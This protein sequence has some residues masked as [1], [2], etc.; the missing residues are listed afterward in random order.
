[1]FIACDESG[2]EGEK[3]IGGVT[4]VFA[5]ASVHLGIDTAQDCIRELRDRIRSPATEY[6]ANHVLRAKHRPVLIWLLG[7]LGPLYGNARVFLLDKAQFVVRRLLDALAE[8]ADAESFYREGRTA[9][10][11]DEWQGFLR[12][13]NDLMRTKDNEAAVDCFLDAAATLLDTPSAVGDILKGFDRERAEAF[14]K[15]LLTDPAMVPPMDA[16]VPA[17]VHAV[18]RWGGGEPV[19]VLHDRQTTLSAGRVKQIRAM[20]RLDSLELVVAHTDSRIQMAD[21]VA[22]VARKIVSDRLNGRGDEELMALVEPYAD[23]S[24]PGST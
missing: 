18:Q 6:K 20:C 12:A 10:D 2:Y 1:M 7:P 15:R 19:S 3:L 5:H 13:A 16:L 11:P 14:R 21:F 24:V 4:D 8:E 17:I 22:G 23:P 9:F